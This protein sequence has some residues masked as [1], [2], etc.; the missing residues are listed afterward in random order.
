MKHHLLKKKGLLV[1]LAAMIGGV[2]SAADYNYVFAADGSN[3]PAKEEAN[4]TSA[5]GVV[6]IPTN[7]KSQARGKTIDGIAY[8]YAPRAK[9]FVFDLSKTGIKSLGGMKIAVQNGSSSNTSLTTLEYSTDNTNWVKFDTLTIAGNSA[10]HV[11]SV[12]LNGNTT[13][14]SLT[15]LYVRLTAQQGTYL[16]G[17]SFTDGNATDGTPEY[18]SVSPAENSALDVDGTIVLTFNEVVKSVNASAFTFDVATNATVTGVKAEGNQVYVSYT[19]FAAN[20]NLNVAAGAVTDLTDVSNTGTASIAFEKDATAPELSSFSPAENSTI[21]IQ[22]LGE[23]ARKIKFT[24]NEDIAID[25]TKEVTFGNGVVN[26]QVNASVSGNVLTI[27]YKGLA[28][29][30]TNTL[31]IPAGFVKDLSD[32]AW[33]ATDKTY[34]FVTGSRDNTAPVLTAQSVAGGAANQPIGGAFTL[35]F[36]EEVVIASQTATIGGQP[37][38]LSNNKN[39]VGLT[40]TNAQYSSDVT[41]EVPAGAITDTCGNAYAGTTFTFTTVDKVANGVA[42]VVAADGSGDYIKIQDALDVISDDSKRSIIYVKPGVYSEKLVVAKKNVSL[43]GEDRDKVVITWNECSTTST[44]QNGTYSTGITST[45]TDASYSMLIAA[46]GF[47]GENFTVRNDYD[48]QANAHSDRQAVALEHINS[49]KAVLKNI[50]MVS[51]QDTYYPKSAKKRVYL[52]DCYIQGGTD[53]IFGSGTAFMDGGILKNVPGGQY[54]TA[55]SDPAADQEFGIVISGVE[56]SYADTTGFGTKRK[57]YLGRPWKLGATTTYINTTFEKDMIQPAGWADW[58]GAI[59]DANYSEF[60]S[61]FADGD[62]AADLS[63]RVSWSSVLTAAEAARCNKENA[64]NYGAG[65]AWNPTPYCQEPEVVSNVVNNVGTLSWTPSYFAVGYV[66]YK[67]NVFYDYSE[68]ASYTDAAYTDGD[69]YQVAAYN[70]YGALSAKSSDSTVGVEENEAETSSILVNTI[71]ESDLVFTKEVAS[72]SVLPL[73][74][75]SY[76]F[77]V[78]GTSANVSILPAG[79]YIAFVTDADNKVYA[80]KF[81]KK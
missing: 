30:A 42:A 79:S 28:Y 64:F 65:N 17:C 20:G 49:D 4:W 36:D 72:L 29:D 8:V 63:K 31:T 2:A 37:V 3:A 32:N 15:A 12:N 24:F 18:V 51:F 5:D 19:G 52:K 78:N 74:G 7:D 13:I 56:A 44:L 34:T 14:S 48:Y 35:T 22:D 50:K 38:V 73:T 53:Y 67:N 77:A 41:V 58:S 55:A 27:S 6:I 47:Y 57:F 75:G 26:A 81:V 66:V 9:K 54:M 70:E 43:I 45:G 25:D 11:A 69:V 10:I 71:V 21:H 60:G 59:N 16:Y 80:Q 33:S 40:Y 62:E 23:D 39:V 68:T 76:S 1:A 61:V 46:D